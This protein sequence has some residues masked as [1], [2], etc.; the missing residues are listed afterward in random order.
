MMK[1]FKKNIIRLP[2]LSKNDEVEEKERYCFSKLMTYIPWR[3][4]MLKDVIKGFS[5]FSECYNFYKEKI[6][7]LMIEY[8]KGDSDIKEAFDEISKMQPD[9][10]KN[11]ENL[12]AALNEP[13][14]ESI[15]PMSD[16]IDDEIED[17]HDNSYPTA[18]CT[19]DVVNANRS[20]YAEIRSLNIEQQRIFL[21][22]LGWVR[23]K[24]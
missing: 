3:E 21:Y 7:P 23:K 8:E 16:E 14:I 13:E 11:L 10:E 2:K 12:E 15:F 4:E 17:D 22:V 18:E 24:S 5:S 6:T 9:L 1:K 20:Y 19:K